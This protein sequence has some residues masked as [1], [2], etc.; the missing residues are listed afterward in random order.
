M[1]GG[2]CPPPQSNGILPDTDV[3]RPHPRVHCRHDTR[4]EYYM[5]YSVLARRLLISCPGDV[6]DSDLHL[7]QQAINR[8]NGIYGEQFGAAIIPISWGTHAA[9]E[10][11]DA[12][13]DLLNKQL[14]DRCDICL[15]LFANRLGTPTASADS[16]TDLRVAYSANPVEH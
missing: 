11:G 8:W 13:Q 4:R 7:V 3:T 15:A 6:P 9:A 12:P 1:F 16:G 10:F 2:L 14:V 5:A